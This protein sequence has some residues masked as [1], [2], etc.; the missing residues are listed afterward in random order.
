[1]SKGHGLAADICD[2]EVE[3]RRCS[4]PTLNHPQQLLEQAASQGAATQLQGAT[5]LSSPHLM[6]WLSLTCFSSYNPATAWGNW[7]LR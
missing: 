7:N 2:P 3:D 6:G 5:L 4:W 1:M